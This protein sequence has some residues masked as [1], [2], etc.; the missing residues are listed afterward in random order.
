MNEHPTSNNDPCHAIVGRPPRRTP[1]RE[2]GVNRAALLCH[3]KS[4]TETTSF[5]KGHS[6]FALRT[7]LVSCP[8]VQNVATPHKFTEAS[9]L[10][11]ERFPVAFALSVLF[12]GALWFGLCRELSGEWS[13][14]E[15]YNFGWFVP[16]FALYL[17]WLRWQD[18]PRRKFQISEVRN[19]KFSQRLRSQ[20]LRC[21]CCCRFV[22][23][24]L[25][26]L[27]GDC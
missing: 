10:S 17:F 12:L 22:S 11:R 2:N 4:P 23:L 15:Q 5:P 14:N 7:N 13:V 9:L 6:Q 27:N 16:F 19:L 3:G 1:V 18:R 20:L 21:F 8:P 24:K 25:R 26:I